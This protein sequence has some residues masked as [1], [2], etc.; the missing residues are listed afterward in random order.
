MEASP[1][2]SFDATRSSP[3]SLRR[4]RLPRWSVTRRRGLKK[5]SGEYILHIPSKVFTVALAVLSTQAWGQSATQSAANQPSSASLEEIVVTAEKRRE[6]LQDVPI[7]IT[8]I[9]VGQI[10]TRGIEDVRDLSSAVVSL[11]VSDQ[12]GHLLPSLRGVGTSV[13]GAGAES[14]VAL[15]VDGVYYAD[16]ASAL[17]TFNNIAQIDVLKGPQGTLF[18]RNATGG[19]ISVTT[20]EPSEAPGGKASIS[21]GNYNTTSAKAYVTGGVAAGVAADIALQYSRQGTGYGRNLA[22]GD[23]DNRTPLDFSARSKWRFDPVDGTK[24]MVT[25]EFANMSTSVGNSNHVIRASPFGPML[26]P[27]TSPYDISSDLNPF[28]HTKSAGGNVRLEQELGAARLVSITAYRRLTNEFFVDGD[29]TPVPAVVIDVH[30]DERQFSQEV[31]LLSNY[32]GRFQWVVGGFYFNSTGKFDPFGIALG[33]PLAATLPFPFPVTVFDQ[34]IN[35]E[36]KTASLA[37]FGEA[38]VDLT[39]TTRVTIGGRVTGEKRNFEGTTTG[40]ANGVIQLGNLSPPVTGEQKVTRPTWRLILDQKVGADTLLY[41]SYN[42]GFKSGT[43]NGTN[44][45]DPPLKPETL[46]AYEAG[47][48]STWLDNRVRFNAAGYYYDYKNYQV[49]SI[50]AGQAVYKNAS[51]KIYGA[52]GE[53]DAAVTSNLRVNAGIGWT[54][55]RYAN[56]NDGITNTVIPGGGILQTAGHD[57]SGHVLTY[58]PDMSAQLGVNYS[59]PAFTGKLTFDANYNYNGGFYPEAENVLHQKAFDMTNASVAWSDSKDA[60]T[61]RLWGKNLTNTLAI[62]DIASSAFASIANY[63]PP[64]TYG[65]ELGYKF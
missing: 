12:I 52:E 11:N 32:T 10:Q 33:G 56:F 34:R 7:A 60:L 20:A 38:K 40:V 59:I 58:V 65:I 4:A 64:R 53:L 48:K 42:R 41:A 57:F 26:P 35:S 31:Q 37:G 29:E 54:H 28:V 30:D 17:L 36:Q 43:F 46:D 8:S 44:P 63:Q 39:D 45:P 51:A 23:Y 18:G 47:L 15:Y 22:T 55:A 49:I 25:G 62:T 14:S 50:A 13:V 61:V 2:S 6:N 5:S 19:V 1:T 27:G 24:I 3:M 21:Y 16:A 9:T